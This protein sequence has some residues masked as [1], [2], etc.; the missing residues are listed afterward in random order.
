[1]PSSRCRPKVLLR[2]LVSASACQLTRECWGLLGPSAS[3]LVLLLLL[4]PRPLWD[5]GRSVLYAEDRS[6]FAMRCVAREIA[7]GPC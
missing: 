4:P 7:C 5:R 1:M 2:G 3:D 6:V